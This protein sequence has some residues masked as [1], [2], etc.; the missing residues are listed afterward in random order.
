[1]VGGAVEVGETYEA[2]AAR[3]ITEELGVH[4][5]AR[6]VLKYLCR[7]AISPYWLGL[8]EA[9]ITQPI[10]PDASEIAWHTWLDPADLRQA[11]RTWGF[12]ADAQEVFDLYLAPQTREASD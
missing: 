1:L 12:L 8:H 2:A 3:E 7:G 5:P 9:T 6:L 4:A 10:T 11:I